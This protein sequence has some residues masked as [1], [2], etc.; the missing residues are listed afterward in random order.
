MTV[1]LNIR[2]SM[3]CAL[4]YIRAE[5]YLLQLRQ[6]S[7]LEYGWHDL[8]EGIACAI[9]NTCCHIEQLHW[10]SLYVTLHWARI[11]LMPALQPSNMF[12]RGRCCGGRCRIC[13]SAFRDCVR[14]PTLDEQ[15]LARLNTHSR[16]LAKACS[17]DLSYILAI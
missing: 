3:V 6:E 10:R 16:R 5:I 13:R 7:A 1:I 11:S 12:D 9:C 8:G 15:G 14:Y 2:N 17:N 4:P